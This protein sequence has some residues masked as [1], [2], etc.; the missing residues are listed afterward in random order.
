MSFQFLSAQIL[1]QFMENLIRKLKSATFHVVSKEIP[2]NGT[3]NKP[4][5]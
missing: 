5:Q 2:A 4:I 1:I 3:R